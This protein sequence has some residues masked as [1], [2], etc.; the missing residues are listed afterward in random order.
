M[1]GRKEIAVKSSLIGLLS[2]SSSL[3]LQIISRKVFIQFI[4]EEIL[5][6]NGTFT[7]ILSTLSLAELGFQSA[8]SFNLYSPICEKDENKI[9][10]IVNIF[11]LVYRFLGIFFIIASIV[12]LPFLKFFL[13]DIEITNDIY[14]YFLLQALSSSCTYF[15]AYKRT[16][17]YADQKEYVYKTIDTI[18][19]FIFKSAQ[20]YVIV[21]LHDYYLYLIIQIVQVYVSNIIVHFICK[22]K[23]P[24]LHKEK[25][26]K[27][28]LKKIFGDVKEISIG[29][30][31]AYVYASTDNLIISKFLGT[32]KVAAL[33]NYTTV[34]TNLRLLVN[35]ILG[36]MTPIIGNYLAEKKE[37][38]N[39]EKKFDLYFHL[40]YIFDLILLV[41]TYVLVDDFVAMWLDE[42]FVLPEEIKILLIADI[43]IVILHGACT[44]YITAKGLFKQNR[45]ILGVSTI[46]NLVI[47]LVGVKL[48]GI[49]G[50]L[51]G[52]VCSQIYNYLGYGLIVYKYCFVSKLKGFGRYILRSIQY[53]VCFLIIVFLCKFVYGSLGM[54]IG[55]VKF[56]CGGIV[57]E[58]LIAI[59]YLLFFIG[60]KERKEMFSIITQALKK[61]I[62]SMKS[63]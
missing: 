15:L 3:V 5:G 14:F 19:N 16:I 56:F 9:N 50:V 60:N 20:I 61:K 27:A 2:Q 13:R 7:S 26:N 44:D 12:I 31:A 23:Y 10:A 39:Q 33:G 43:Y 38:G 48:W 11:R 6:L 41:P 36:P 47:S 45:Q 17:M 34:I 35:S 25:L 8:I 55:L 24:Y 29:R 51:F 22:K 21:K 30:L 1:S 40:R 18:M 32:V 42:S 37:E 54:G 53:T 49:S 62:I 59:L 28:Y 46:L 57:C 52:T 4:G 63:R 58:F